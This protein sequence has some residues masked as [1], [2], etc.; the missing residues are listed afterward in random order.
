MHGLD[1]NTLPILRLG[2]LNSY[3]TNGVSPR[4]MYQS[5]PGQSDGKGGYNDT[6]SLN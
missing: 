5:A 3:K 1:V 6:E 4:L 2:M